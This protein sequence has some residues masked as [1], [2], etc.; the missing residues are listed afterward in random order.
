VLQVHREDVHRRAF[1]A[2]HIEELAHVRA[3]TPGTGGAKPA[4]KGGEA[5]VMAA[6]DAHLV[7]CIDKVR[8]I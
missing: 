7:A 3:Q 2:K 4:G 1:S 6:T 5:P 8:F